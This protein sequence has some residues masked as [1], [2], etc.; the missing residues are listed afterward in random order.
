MKVFRL[1]NHPVKNT[2]DANSCQ[3]VLNRK[4]DIYVC[5]L[6]FTRNVAAEGKYIDVVSTMVET[7]NPEK[8][9]QPGLALLEPIM[10]K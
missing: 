10:E 9:V 4:S 6:S 5:L 2:H 3:I 7:C 8:E 1:L